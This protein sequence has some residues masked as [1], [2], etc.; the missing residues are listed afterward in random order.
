MGAR[1]GASA[2]RP[3]KITAPSWE[4]RDRERYAARG[5]VESPL[6]RGERVC[7]VDPTGVW[8]GLKLKA[9]GKSGAYPIVVFGGEHADFPHG[10]PSGS[11]NSGAQRRVR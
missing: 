1:Y 10:Q 9:S 6:D 5:I 11:G 4:K 2:N 7:I 3:L 8:F